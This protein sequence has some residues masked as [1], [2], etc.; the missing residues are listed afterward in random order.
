MASGLLESLNEDELLDLLSRG[1][2]H[3]PS[4]H[5]G[6]ADGDSSRAFVEAAVHAIFDRS[7]PSLQRN[8]ERAEIERD[9]A[10]A[11]LAHEPSMRRLVRLATTLRSRGSRG[12]G[13][14]A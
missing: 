8:A 2:R 7:F 6:S 3:L 14:G 5:D 4:G 12:N 10:D 1:T 9:V 11:L 13:G